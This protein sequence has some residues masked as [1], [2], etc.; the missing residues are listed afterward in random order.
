MSCFNS[1]NVV[2]KWLEEW[3][4]TWT[5]WEKVEEHT[6]VEH[7][8]DNVYEIEQPIGPNEWSVLISSPPL[9]F[10]LAN[11]SFLRELL[12]AVHENG[13]QLNNETE[14]EEAGDGICRRLFGLIVDHVNDLSKDH[15]TKVEHSNRESGD[16]M[17]KLIWMQQSILHHVQT[18]TC[19]RHAREV[20]N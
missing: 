5:K 16:R 7:R 8:W 11:C 18:I 1:T 17:V 2:F 15:L 4:E 12:K 6:F 19:K 3:N 14:T 20:Q 9:L 13:R 10:K